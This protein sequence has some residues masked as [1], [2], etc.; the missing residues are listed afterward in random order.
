MGSRIFS[1]TL[2]VVAAGLAGYLIVAASEAAN[3]SNRFIDSGQPRE[4]INQPTCWLSG[5]FDDSGQ[6][7]LAHRI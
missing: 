3:R 7:E 1:A 5:Q 4:L 2:G 6:C